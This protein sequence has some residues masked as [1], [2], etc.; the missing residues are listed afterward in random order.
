MSNEELAQYV[1]E[2]ELR[3]AR[4]EEARDERGPFQRIFPV[5]R[6]PA[7]REQWAE[8]IMGDGNLVDL[9]D[10]RVCNAND[11]ARLLRYAAPG[12]EFVI[13]M[14]DWDTGSSDRPSRYVLLHLE[15]GFWGA[16]S[17]ATPMGGEVNR[18]TY[19]IDEV[20]RTS[21]YAWISPTE[22][23]GTTYAMNSIETPNTGAG[24]EGNGVDHGSADYPAGFSMQPAAVGAV[25]WV[26]IEMDPDGLEQYTFEYANA[27][28][29]PCS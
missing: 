22:P 26:R 15:Q 29:G 16:I 6:N 3:L 7:I 25:V 13:E 23:R 5:K 19:T 21:G 9:P 27:E 28:T 11:R 24:V 12:V 18:W 10:G 17:A 4:L 2:L 14:E 1:A 20:I 8:Q